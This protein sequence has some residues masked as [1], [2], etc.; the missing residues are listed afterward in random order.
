M[1]KGFS[2]PTVGGRREIRA[3]TIILLF[4]GE[5]HRYKPEK[6]TGWDECWVGFTGPVTDRLFEKNF[7]TPDNPTIAVGYQEDL[8]NIF[9]EIIDTTKKEATGYQPLA[10]GA[11]L[12]ILGRIY[13]L[14][15]QEKFEGQEIAPLIDKA[16]LIFRNNIEGHISPEDVAQELKI[17]Y[18]RFRKIFKEYTGLAPGQFQIPAQDPPGK[19]LLADPARLIKEIAYDLNFE[20]NFYFS[21]LFKEKT[22]L[23]PQQYP[24]PRHG[25]QLVL[26]AIP[27]HHLLSYSSFTCGVF[28]KLYKTQLFNFHTILDK[29]SIFIVNG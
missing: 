17:S 23:T 11:V 7:F 1:V 24:R 2:N 18:S 13:H 8:L 6:K 19:E 26:F 16:R 25:P 12:H 22:G 5:R 14:S 10:A 20:S 29:Q 27:V 4:P 9:R 15:Q 21:K 3:G 28:Q